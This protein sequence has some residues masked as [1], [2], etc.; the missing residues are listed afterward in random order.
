MKKFLVFVLVLFMIGGLF[1]QTRPEHR[2]L[3][4]TW[5]TRIDYGGGDYEE[6]I[7]TFNDN[8]TGR[9]QLNEVYRG[10]R[11]EESFNFLFSLD[12]I[13]LYMFIEEDGYIDYE[14]FQVHRINDQRMII[15]DW[16]DVLDFRKR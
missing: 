4:G 16:G 13:E 9:W 12:G 2:W 5:A 3:L 1:A 14:V 6:F 10:Q 8:G 15:N 7:W 11:Y